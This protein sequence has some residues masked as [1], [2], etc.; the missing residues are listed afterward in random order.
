MAGFK[1]K[2]RTVTVEIEGKEYA[3]QIG[4]AEMADR[5]AAAYTNLQAIG[6]EQVAGNSKVNYNVS[7][8]LRDLIGAILGKEAQDA[9]FESRPHSV[10][11]EI[12]LLQYLMEQVNA[13]ESAAFSVTDAIDEV[14]G[15]MQPAAAQETP[16]SSIADKLAGR[17]KAAAAGAEE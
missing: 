15:I 7:C 8:M 16:I 17:A 11:D 1:F 2:D 13:S 4:S 3:I 6:G 9:I 10:I 5:V 14:A 12:E